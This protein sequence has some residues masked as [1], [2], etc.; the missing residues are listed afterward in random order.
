MKTLFAK[1]TS[2]KSILSLAALSILLGAPAWALT[3][4]ALSVSDGTNTVTVDS[5]GTATCTGSA[6]STAAKS[7]AAGSISWSGQIGDFSISSLNVRTKPALGSATSPLTDMSIGSVTTGNVG[8]TL[9]IKWSDQSF[10]G[11][12]A[13]TLNVVQTM[14]GG[15]GTYSTYWDTNNT[16]LATTNQ[17]ATTGATTGSGIVITGTGPASQPFSLTEVAVLAIGPGGFSNGDFQLSGTPVPALTLACPVAS[18]VANTAYSSSLV[19]N[20]GAPGYTYSLTSG[21]LPMGLTLNANGSITGTPTATGTFTF[22]PQVTDVAGETAAPGS[23]C[24]ITVTTA[25]PLSLACP[26]N[27]TGIVGAMFSGSLVA[28]GGVT[29]Y[30][31]FAVSSGSLPAGLNLN[32]TTGAITG[33][34]TAAGSSTFSATVTDSNGTTSASTASAANCGVTINAAPTASCV[35]INAIQGV[36]ITSATLIGSGGAGGT[37]TFSATGLPTGLSMSSGG[38]ISG[39]PSVSGTFSYT[40]TIKDSKGNTGTIT[41]SI[42]VYAPITS[43]CPSITATQGLAINSVTLTASGGS[44]S[45]YTFTSTNLPAGLSISSTGTISGT[46]TGSGTFSYTVTIKDGAGNTGTLNCS[47]TISTAT[48]TVVPLSATCPTATATAGTAYSSAAIS[49]GVPPYTI[50]VTGTL[51]PGLTVNNQGVLSGTPTQAGSFSFSI[52]ATD[53]KGTTVGAT[54]NSSSTGA[55]WDFTSRE[56][57]LGSD[58][59]FNQNGFNIEAYGYRNDGKPSN[60]YG[61]NDSYGTGLGISGTNW[62]NDLD[63]NNFIQCDLG[64][65]NSAGSSSAT[66]NLQCQNGGSYDVYGSNTPGQ[67]G[68]PIQTNCTGSSTTVKTSGYRYLCVRA[69]QGTVRLCGVNVNVPKLCTITVAPG[70]QISMTKTANTSSAS[71]F[72]KVTYTYKVTNTG[73]TTV[74]NILV[75]DNGGVADYAGDGF[76]VGTIPSLT[77]GAS[78][79]LTASVYLPLTEVADSN[80]WYSCQQVPGGTLVAQMLAN[81]NLQVTFRQDKG[82]IDNTYGTNASS[83]WCGGHTFSSFLTGN[84]AEFQFFDGKGNLVLDFYADYLSPSSSFPS[85]YGSLGLGGD[86][87]MVLGNKS[88]VVSINTTLANNLNQNGFTGYTTNSPAAGVTGWDTVDGYTVVINPAVF[89]SNGFGS[90]TVPN[91]WDTPSKIGQ[92]G[93]HTLHVTNSTVTNIATATGTAGTVSVSTTASAT[94]S[95]DNNCYGNDS[96]WQQNSGWGWGGW[97]YTTGR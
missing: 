78:A 51:P 24:T 74:N 90:V 97:S 54:C 59:S 79:T 47:I 81:G 12:G 43:S 3:G 89:G 13:L 20:G 5:T 39:T 32:A 60:L 63:T 72:Q 96:Y 57:S 70:P 68:L 25:S 55:K 28:T 34:P 82:V 11:L 29:P 27:N 75:T 10:Y 67:L 87:G 92:S 46:P 8:G 95:I 2:M 58:E 35:S 17:S 84:K 49:G 62:N 50:S 19:A 37:Y 45:G 36:A 18:G 22:T 38:T 41:C 69:H 52:G 33:T 66:L 23:A 86:G 80:G 53:S 64:Q 61:R 31:M 44:G 40:V 26:A 83:T 1:L 71:P 4:P 88:Y 85:G 21:S 56:G 16:L 77:P 42:T 15:T 93:D 65:T 30:K 48:P 9:T 73:G 14:I 94:V 7:V 76:T 6:C 91:V